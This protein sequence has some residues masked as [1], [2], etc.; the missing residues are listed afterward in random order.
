[1]RGVLAS[2]IVN[3]IVLMVVAGYFDSFHL[4][5]VG[6]AIVASI[7]LSIMNVIVKPILIILTLP[8]TVI[9]LGLFLI[10]INAITLMLTAGIMGDAFTIDGFG[11]AIIASI[12]ISL[13]N[14]LITKFIVE[15]LS[16]K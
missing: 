12:V 2:L 4:S 16:K 5:G 15:P 7:L 3:T 14:L 13:L 1:M 10:V 11:T 6:A 9:T 8:V